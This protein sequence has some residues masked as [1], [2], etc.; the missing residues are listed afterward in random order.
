MPTPAR[1]RASVRAAAVP[2]YCCTAAV[3]LLF[4]APGTDITRFQQ[5]EARVLLNLVHVFSL[6]TF[7]TLVSM[8]TEDIRN[9]VD[10]IRM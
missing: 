5:L 1:A 2:L 9:T 6:F 7:A 3:P 4:A 10:Q 8:F